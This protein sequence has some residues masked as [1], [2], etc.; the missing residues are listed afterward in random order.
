[1]ILIDGISKQILS[2][3]YKYIWSMNELMKTWMK[4]TSE[5]YSNTHTTIDK[6]FIQNSHFKTGVSYSYNHIS[7]NYIK[8]M[9]LILH[10]TGASYSGAPCWPWL[11]GRKPTMDT[12]SLYSFCLEHFFK[13][14]TLDFTFWYLGKE[15]TFLNLAW[16]FTV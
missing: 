8:H 10:F 2:Y 12:R 11:Q 3:D 4:N 15:L 1:M 7:L 6:F 5:K 13:K 14:I 9:I 16:Y